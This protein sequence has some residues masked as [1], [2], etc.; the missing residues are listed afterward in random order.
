MMDQRLD[1]MSVVCVRLHSYRRFSEGED[2][3][4]ELTGTGAKQY[5]RFLEPAVNNESGRDGARRLRLR[6]S[7]HGNCGS[8]R[9]R[10]ANETFFFGGKFR[11]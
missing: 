5:A 7:R 9:R 8:P 4:Q 10:C 1:G 11:A 3:E 6:I 2:W